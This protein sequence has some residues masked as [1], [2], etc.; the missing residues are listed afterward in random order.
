[1]KKEIL[2]FSMTAVMTVGV[3]FSGFADEW[4]LDTIGY[5]YQYTDGS[6]AKDGFVK[7]GEDWYYFDGNGYMQTGW[8]LENGQWF[9]MASSGK[10]LTGWQ[11]IDDARYYLD[12]NG[13]M[14]VNQWRKNEENWNYVG[15]DGKAVSGWQQIDGKWYYFSPYGTM[16]TGW[17]ELDKKRY[18][19]KED[20]SLQTGIFEQDGTWYGTN[21]SGAIYKSGRNKTDKNFRYGDDG[22]I[23]RYN[24]EEGVWEY[25]AGKEESTEMLLD[26]MEEDYMAGKYQSEAE[27]E[28]HVRDSLANSSLTE[29]EIQEFID[30]VELRYMLEGEDTYEEYEDWNHTYEYMDEGDYEYSEYYAEVEDTD[31]KRWYSYMENGKIYLRTPDGRLFLQDED[32]YLWQVE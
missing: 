24:E 30:K 19:L 29:R 22:S 23:L 26:K 32:G 25:M 21:A 28:Q 12:E 1:M 16:Q 17:L 14:Q 11:S 2:M 18:F 7:I 13:A 4:K 10:M 6:Y 27:F 3:S 9:Y 31:G 20:G 5:Y 8:K 15:A